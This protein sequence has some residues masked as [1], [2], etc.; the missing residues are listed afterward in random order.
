MENQRNT[1]DS[2]LLEKVFDAGANT[3]WSEMKKLRGQAPEQKDNMRKR[4]VWELIQNA[5]DCIP[6]GGQVNINICLRDDRILEFTHDGVPFT[7]EN[8]I[9]LITQ[10]SS[11]QSDTEEK[12]GKFGTGFISTHLLSEKVKI[13]GV[14][15][16]NENTYKNLNFILDRSGNSYQDVR[17]KIKETLNFI[18]Y[19]KQDETKIIEK[20]NEIRTTFFYNARSSQETQEAIKV[21]LEDL[22]ITIPFVLALNK[23]IQSIT[24]NEA[25]YEIIKCS[26][27]LS[28]EYELVEIRNPFGEPYNVLIK[29]QNEVCIA[30]LVERI[31]NHKYRVL[32]FQKNIPKLFCKFPLIGTENFSFPITLNC[33][34]FEVEK[35]RNAIHEGSQEN[36]EFLKISIKLYETLINDASKNEWE[37]IYNL[38]FVGR[39]N[40]SSIQKNYVKR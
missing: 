2:I 4:W 10:I 28:D 27:E 24:C 16:Q 13:N 30:I 1:N 18:E 32:P 20:P 35:D 6:K 21:G 15:K 19:L 39:N 26:K 8:L 5:S 29:E 22:K 11:K 3:I 34:K 25:R 23:S 9:D 33:S 40:D 31:T 36:I 12:T 7:Y 17:S 38:C 37:D 14:F